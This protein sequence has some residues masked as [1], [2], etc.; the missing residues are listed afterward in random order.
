MYT[1]AWSREE[2]NRTKF[3]HIFRAATFECNAGQCEI[4]LLLTL[5]HKSYIRCVKSFHKLAN[6]QMYHKF[7][8][9]MHDRRQKY[10]T[11]NV[12]ISK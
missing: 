1:T 5:F 9:H 7:D 12:W 4:E 8:M 11:T 3:M 2:V 10:Y 6:F